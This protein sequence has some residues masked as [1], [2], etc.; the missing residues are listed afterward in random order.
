MK[1]E[2]FSLDLRPKPSLTI[3]FFISRGLLI[4]L[5]ISLIFFLT[6]PLIFDIFFNPSNKFSVYN[7]V[8]AVN[9]WISSGIALS[10]FI[11]I[12]YCNTLRKSLRLKVDESH[13]YLKGGV[14]FKIETVVPIKS[15]KIVQS[16][17]NFLERIFNIYRIKIYFNSSC[18]EFPGVEKGFELA[19][20]LLELK[21]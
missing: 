18:V 2:K 16:S 4:V 14:L 8:F 11:S 20:F 1:K 17:Q 9:L 19:N 5:I 21:S 10:F 12:F 7:S 3:Y 6:S 13:I 15:L